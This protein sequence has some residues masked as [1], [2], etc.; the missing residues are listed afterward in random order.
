MTRTIKL[1]ILGRGVDTDAPTVDDLL[2]QV[3]D[4]F[5]ILRGVEQ[6]VAEDGSSAIEWRIVSA[7]MNSPLALE[8]GA[9]PRQ[10]AMNV[11]H[12]AKVV[13]THAANGL[14]ALQTSS[15]RPPFFS[16]KAL[17]RA[18]R[19]FERVTN[20][21]SETAVE[22]GLG[23]PPTTLNRDNATSAAANVKA[24][25]K[26]QAK[27]YR[28][29]GSIEAVAHGFDRDGWGHPILKVRHRL[30]G[31]DINCRV[32]GRA[33]EAVEARQV[34]DIWSSCRVQLFGTIY[35]KTLG[36]ISR[37]DAQEIR[38][39]RGRFELPTL[40]DVVDER[41]TG[42]LLS[43]DYLERMHNGKLS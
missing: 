12:R 9:F 14:N 41:F 34:G 22:Y 40:D 20:G 4:Y 30:T 35:Y 19:F 31:D 36:R 26:P 21:L 38:F 3:R 5:E 17:A 43:E 16:E 39:L 27:P 33:L 25:L 15:K 10:F 1:K 8:A 11:D 24:I 2:D 28:E 6:A 23:L 42:G 13:I 29:I 7:S 18:E 32:A 37:M